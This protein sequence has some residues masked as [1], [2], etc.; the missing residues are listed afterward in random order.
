MQ[1]KVM[2]SFTGQQVFENLVAE[3]SDKAK[4]EDTDPAE[5]GGR[6]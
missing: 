5:P 6:N 4:N 2:G 1:A 3:C